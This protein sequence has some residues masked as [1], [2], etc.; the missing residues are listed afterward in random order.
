M[1]NPHNGTSGKILSKTVRLI[2]K[3]SRAAATSRV[4]TFLN[5]GKVR[6]KILHVVILV[7][8]TVVCC[9]LVQVQIINTGKYREMAQKQYQAKITLLAQRG[10]IFD[11]DSNM[12]ARNLDFLSFAADPQ[13]VAENAN[14][15]AAMFSKVFGKPKKYYLEKLNTD[16]RFVWLERQVSNEISKKI[17]LHK[18][19]GL[20]SQRE[21]KRIYHNDQVAGQLIGVTNIDNKGLA[22]IELEFDR[23]LRGKDGYEIFQR[24][25]RQHAHPSVD[26][27]KVE[28]TNG[29]N[30]FLTIDRNLQA[31][32]EKALRKGVEDYKADRGIIVIMQPATGEVLAIGQYPPID[33]NKFNTYDQQD[34]RLRAVTDVFEP[35]SVFKLV[36]ASAA[37]E[38]HII[39]PEQKFFAENGQY[40]VVYNGGKSRPITDTHKH[41]W[42][43]FQEAMEVSSNIVMA[44]A[45]NIIGTERFYRMERAYGFGM[46]T[47]IEYPGEVN[48]VLSK[49][50]AWSG[51]TLNS[52]SYGY[53]VQ[54]TA[55]QITAAY[56]AVA[57][58][59]ILM[60]PML[61]QKE[62]DATGIVIRENHIE[63]IRRVISE[64]TAE[65][66]KKILVGVVDTGTGKQ[67]RIRGVKIAG[68]TGTS[69]KY[70]DGH[71]EP[72]SYRASF[73][74]FFPA[75]APKMV[76]F[77]MMDN[78]RVPDFYGGSTSAPVFRTIAQH[79]INTTESFATHVVPGAGLRE[80]KKRVSPI[81][82]K[83]QSKEM[84]I[85]PVTTPIANVI[86]D[87]RGYSLRRALKTLKLGNF[88]P[89]AIGSGTVVSEEPSPGQPAKSGMKITLMC[90]D[91]SLSNL[92]GK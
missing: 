80:G 44:K 16:S 25:G 69:K 37:L 10:I 90:E 61:F 41:G 66:L 65:T 89:V 53:E 8:F 62:T 70:I 40:V 81:E 23:E 32:S 35:G 38:N 76:C 31:L 52:M 20:V 49:P 6:I 33:P 34:Q 15:I 11:R 72:G 17:D 57:N 59:G 21:Q 71:Y 50:S 1:I 12:L 83:N 28:P 26:Y 30:I 5:D 45:S 7:F 2:K 86:P 82:R 24:D 4:A 46:A 55:I 13:V 42:I 67:A 68:K 64:K 9:R 74:G 19:L 51:L 36:T 73:V 91:K 85:V 29:H 56:C 54:T 92:S 14:G 63:Q 87:V 60:K 79:V 48:G 84:E 22:G 75:D 47:N 58:N 27:P 39:A 43:T 88:T 18:F 77:V 3:I 78:P